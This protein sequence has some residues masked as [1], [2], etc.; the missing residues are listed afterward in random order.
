M[1]EKPR[2]RRAGSTNYPLAFKQQVALEAND[3][4]RSVAE[5]ALEHGLNT[6][7]VSRWRRQYPSPSVSTAIQ[8]TETF[9]AVRVTEPSVVQTA[10]IIEHG[11][12]RVRFEGSPDP[13]VLLTVLRALRSTT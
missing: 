4:E 12:L 8:P 1:E 6:N 9:V 10:V 7:M 5:V 13:L 3:P 2:G 11:D